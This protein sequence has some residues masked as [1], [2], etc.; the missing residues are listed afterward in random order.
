MMSFVARVILHAAAALVLL[1]IVLLAFE[2]GHA[3]AEGGRE[4]RLSPVV[5]ALGGFALGKHP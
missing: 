3:V 4:Q 1:V 5:L 2:F